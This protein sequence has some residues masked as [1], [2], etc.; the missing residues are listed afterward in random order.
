MGTPTLYMLIV[1]LL[2]SGV[3][4]TPLAK[5]FTMDIFFY[6]M[7]R[8]KGFQYIRLKISNMPTDVIAYYIL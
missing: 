1:K 5:L 2:I 6:L 8:L 3:V 7:T 4:S